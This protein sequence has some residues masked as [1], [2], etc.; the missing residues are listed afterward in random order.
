MVE[1]AKITEDLFSDELWSATPSF[2]IARYLRKSGG[3]LKV[4]LHHLDTTEVLKMDGAHE[5]R[6]LYR[7]PNSFFG[8]S[9]FESLIV[10]YDSL[11]DRKRTD[12]YI[13]VGGFNAIT[14]VF[15]KK[16][17][18]VRKTIFYCFDFTERRFD[19]R[20][21]NWIYLAV[22]IVS[23]R[24]SDQV[25]NVSTA[26]DQLRY[27]QGLAS[28]KTLL[29]PIGVYSLQER[30]T[31]LKRHR[32]IYFG[33][34]DQFKGVMLA[35][36]AM[37]SIIKLVSDAELIVMGDG[38]IRGKISQRVSELNISDHVK[39]MGRV[40]YVTAGEVLGEG[41]IGV[42]PLAP[43]YISPYA[44]LQKVKEYVRFGCPVIIT[45]VA[46]VHKEIAMR[47]AGVVIRYDLDEFIMAAIKLM[48]SDQLFEE[49]SI[50]A[51]KMAK[52][53]D[54]TNIFARALNS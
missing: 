4:I 49:C 6:R 7:K 48:S 2:T 9:L 28:G 41:G 21:L 22:D 16:I 15:L 40:S 13:G 43:Q 47:H 24:G 52:D 30:P 8:R 45:D 5:Q 54:W 12:L 38:P 14:G 25:W 19:N 1:M 50:N 27:G 53:Y 23:A 29:V 35:I 33:I 42:A 39:I 31:P 37:P 34:L 46:P 26:I 36:E 51:F 3:N 18:R 17:G 32:I 44:D 10:I 20:L 11:L